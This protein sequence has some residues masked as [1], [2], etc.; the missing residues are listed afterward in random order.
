MTKNDRYLGTQLFF[1]KNRKANFEPLL[2]KYYSTL[3]GWKSK[4]LSQAGR[5]FLIKSILQAF[6]TYQMQV[7]ALPKETL[8]QLDRI[9]R[10]FWWNKEGQKR[11][12]GFIRAWKY[13]C[14]PIAQG[15]LG[16]KNP[17]QFNITLLT[18]LAS[19]LIIEK[20]K[21]WAKI[22]KAKYF[23]NSHP[24]EA[25]K[26]SNLS[27]IWTSSRKGLDLI[28]GNFIWQV[29]NGNSVKIWEDRWI[30]NSDIPS[31]PQ[32]SQGTA[33]TTVQELITEDNT[34]DQEK[35]NSYINPEVRNK[36]QAI[37]PNK[38]E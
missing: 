32:D 22:I 15:G 34:W 24:L 10:N 26:S 31:Q 8:N 33:P 3:Q 6:P 13:I 7:L 14:Q 30:P 17:H 4:L 18:K 36:I 1:D 27:W 12:G 35:L 16:I 21:L 25:S 20:Y 9:Q 28:K 29:K 2:Q 37:S 38:E 5:T 23:P 19:R 11:Q